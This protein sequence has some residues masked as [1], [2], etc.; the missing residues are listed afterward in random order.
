[1]VT[2][3]CTLAAIEEVTQEELG[4]KAKIPAFRLIQDESSFYSTRAI[5]FLGCKDVML[6]QMFSIRN[7]GDLMIILESFVERAKEGLPELIKADLI[8]RGLIDDDTSTT[9]HTG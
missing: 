8:K 3:E 2:D 4:K 7:A 5:I 9:R 6:D 1:M